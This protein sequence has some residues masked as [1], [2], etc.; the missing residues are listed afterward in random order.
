MGEILITAYV[1]L[2]GRPLDVIR[3][4][5]PYWAAGNFFQSIWCLA[6]RPKFKQSLWLPMSLLA[7]GSAS[8]FYCHYELSKGIEA[9]WLP[10][11]FASNMSLSRYLTFENLWKKLVLLIVRFPVSLHASWLTAASLLNLNA[12]SAVSNVSMGDQVAIG[13]FSAYFASIA[14]AF[15][16]YKRGDPF[17][18]LTVAWA[19]AALAAQTKSRCQVDLPV[20]TIDALARTVSSI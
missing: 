11:L 7:S 15:L 5:T 20:D 19:L 4:S 8:L 17:I 16:S 9:L 2:V 3:K 12:W 1:G 6:F 14:G 13:F 10:D 18:A